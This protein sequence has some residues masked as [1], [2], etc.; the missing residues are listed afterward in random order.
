[1]F[2]KILKIISLII[3]LFIIVFAGLYF[4]PPGQ[5]EIRYNYVTKEPIFN[6]NPKVG[7]YKTTEGLY[8]QVTWGAKTGLQLN[9]FDSLRI[10]IK[11]FLLYPVTE[12]KFDS[13]GDTN[14]IEAIFERSP[15]NLT[16]TLTFNGK[17]TKLQ[18]YSR[19]VFTTNKVRSGI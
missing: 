13:D 4:I 15:N 18:L 14:N 12:N 2:R 3:L 5:E 16:Y 9:Y 11:S 6:L 8:Y 17:K 1:M 19:T 7:W 10:N